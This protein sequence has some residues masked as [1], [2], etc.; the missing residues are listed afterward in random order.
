M[1]ATSPVKAYRVS[2]A[3]GAVSS[4]K[5]S[6]IHMLIYLIYGPTCSGKT[7]AAI[8]LHERPDGRSLRWIVYNAVLKSPP[9]A[10]VP[11]IPNS[12]LPSGS[13]WI[14]AR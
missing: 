8:Q 12:N 5:L 3:W 13:T 6:G 14:R 7:D 9:A 11:R 2:C 4:D 10:G 1:F